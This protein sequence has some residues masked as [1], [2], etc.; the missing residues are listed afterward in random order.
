VYSECKN[1]TGTKPRELKIF[2]C[3]LHQEM[4]SEHFCKRHYR[5]SLMEAVA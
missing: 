1:L 3:C 4:P 5:A 2:L